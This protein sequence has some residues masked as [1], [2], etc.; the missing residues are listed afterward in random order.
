[1][2]KILGQ[3]IQN[4]KIGLLQSI[5]GQRKNVQAFLIRITRYIVNT[6]W[7]NIIVECVLKCLT[8][9][10][11]FSKIIYFVLFAFLCRSSDLLIQFLTV[12]LTIQYQSS[13]WGSP[14]RKNAIANLSLFLSFVQLSLGNLEVSWPQPDHVFN[15]LMKSKCKPRSV[16]KV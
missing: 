3:P 15:T 5:V 7:T 9:K 1:M 14:E 10:I 2:K 12:K 8:R 11:S 6:S 13:R 16:Q 4:F